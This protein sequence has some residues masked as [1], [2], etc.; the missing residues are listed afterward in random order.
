MP[1]SRYRKEE[2][3]P[4]GQSLFL[5]ESEFKIIQ[6]LHSS[7]R[8]FSRIRGKNQH[9]VGAVMSVNAQGTGS[10]EVDEI[11]K[12]AATAGHAIF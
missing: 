6:P 10:V 2:S 11:S 12:K 4:S 8:G 1:H 5:W 9:G 3:G 7:R